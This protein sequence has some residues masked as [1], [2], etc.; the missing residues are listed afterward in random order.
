MDVRLIPCIRDSSSMR[1]EI[2]D[3]PPG[4]GE[5]REDEAQRRQVQHC[6]PGP[7]AL[8]GAT[9]V[10][11]PDT[12]LS[13][14]CLRRFQGF[15]L[16]DGGVSVAEAWNFAFLVRSRSGTASSPSRSPAKSDGRSLLFWSC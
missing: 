5:V 10:C 8:H 2:G 15:S 11:W 14:V 9:V 1:D 4:I 6:E 16:A 3:R 7:V 12:D 13:C